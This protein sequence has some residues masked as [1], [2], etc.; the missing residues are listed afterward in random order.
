MTATNRSRR[1]GVAGT[2][3]R[4]CCDTGAE[5]YSGYRDSGGYR[6]LDDP[7]ALL[8]EVDLSGIARPWRR[9]VP[10]G[11]QAAAPCATTV[12]AAGGAVV[13]ANG[14]EGEPA[15]IKDRWLLRHRPH[16]VLDGLRLAA[17]MVSS[18]PCVCLR[19]RSA[20]PQKRCEARLPR[21]T[22][23]CSTA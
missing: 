13:V 5:D 10:A 8:D 3:S 19:L 23:T 11:G 15:S 14:E 21:S 17:R 6:P 18:R 12:G 7:D 2:S 20:L 4:G 16:L 9:S 22:A 1:R